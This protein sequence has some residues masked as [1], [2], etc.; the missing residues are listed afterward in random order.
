MSQSFKGVPSDDLSLEAAA[1]AYYG[2]V[3]KICRQNSSTRVGLAQGTDNKKFRQHEYDWFGQDTWKIRRNLTLTLGLRY[4]L[5][6]VPYE[7]NA[8]FSNLLGDPTAGPVTLSMV[9]PGTGKQLYANDYSNIE[10]RVGFSWD[11][12]GDGKMA[13]RGAFGIFHDRVFGNLFRQRP[14]QSA[15]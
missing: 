3:D 1:Q 10:P 11:P 5:D 15:V 2:F 6:G 12:K 14:R 9:G 4:Q 7:E 13:V 8:N